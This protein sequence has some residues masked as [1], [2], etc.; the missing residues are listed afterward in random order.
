[1]PGDYV[2]VTIDQDWD[3]KAE[4]S[5]TMSD[6]SDLFFA[7]APRVRGIRLDLLDPT[8]NND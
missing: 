3:I 4:H 6:L 7:V 1:V 5:D 2:V 8:I